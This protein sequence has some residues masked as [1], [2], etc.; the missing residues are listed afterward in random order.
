MKLEMTEKDL[1][2]KLENAEKLELG[3]RRR[4][5]TPPSTCDDTE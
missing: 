5:T 2:A 1:R 3:V 4:S